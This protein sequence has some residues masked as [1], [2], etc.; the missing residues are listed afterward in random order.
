MNGPAAMQN[1]KYLLIYGYCLILSDDARFFSNADS[2]FKLT[3]GVKR[4]GFYQQQQR[5]DFNSTKKYLAV[6]KN[7]W[8]CK[9]MWKQSTN[10]S[11]CD[12]QV[13]NV[14]RQFY[15]FFIR[16]FGDFHQELRLLCQ[17]FFVFEALSFSDVMQNHYF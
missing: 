10:I 15:D 6:L 2:R 3:F 13:L 16:K 17:V 11:Q 14:L 1:G 8:M 9:Y 12:T 5:L 7:N 4:C